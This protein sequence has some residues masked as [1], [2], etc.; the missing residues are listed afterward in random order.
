M[1]PHLCKRHSSKSPARR[2]THVVERLF[3]RRKRHLAAGRRLLWD[4]RVDTL[5]LT[6]GHIQGLIY[7]RDSRFVLVNIRLPQVSA[8]TLFT[9]DTKMMQIDC[10]E[11]HY[12]GLSR[13]AAATLLAVAQTFRRDH[14][15][16]TRLS[17]PLDVDV[18]MLPEPTAKKEVITLKPSVQLHHL[19]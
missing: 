16:V 11:K 2:W 7:T 14:T 17:H 18:P 12:P 6:P 8:E 13:Y 15:A 3:R 10:S 4:G 19:F 9:V 1:P 5:R